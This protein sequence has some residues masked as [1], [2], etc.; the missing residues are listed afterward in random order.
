MS[1]YSLFKEE[2]L[3]Y[4]NRSSAAFTSPT[5]S[6]DLVLAAM[7]D[8]ARAAQRRYTFNLNRTTAFG[9]LSLAPCSM[10]TDLDTTPV[11]TTLIVAKQVDAVYEYSSAVVGATTRYYRTATVPYWRHSVFQREVGLSSSTFGSATQVVGSLQAATQFTYLQGTNIFHSTLTTVTW[12]MLDIIEW[13]AD[14]DGGSGS[15]I[16]LTYFKDWLKY[17]TLLNMNQFLKDSE[18][19]NIDAAMMAELW[20]SVKQFDAQQGASTGSISLD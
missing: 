5:T 2:V 15:N 4:I 6:I 17:A 13:L 8:A 19:F 9:Q 3:A 10:L 12:Y 20:E 18:R 1:A 16:F 14:H 11:S 7:N